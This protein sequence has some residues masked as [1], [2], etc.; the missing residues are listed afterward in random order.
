MNS[1]SAT[2]ILPWRREELEGEAGKGEIR[3]RDNIL[4]L[5]VPKL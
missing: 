2:Q 4:I 5:K 1:S 3:A